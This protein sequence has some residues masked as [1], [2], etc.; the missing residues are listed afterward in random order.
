MQKIF[1]RLGDGWAIELTE[2]EL[3]QD[4]VDMVSLASK[5]MVEI[6]RNEAFDI[7]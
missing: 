3:M 6:T 2:A 7:K 4:I 1:S 5:A